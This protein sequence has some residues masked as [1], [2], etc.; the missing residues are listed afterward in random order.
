MSKARQRSNGHSDSR[1]GDYPSNGF[2]AKSI[3]PI[4]LPPREMSDDEYTYHEGR[5][6]KKIIDLDERLKD[7]SQQEADARDFY[8]EM[9]EKFFD[10]EVDYSEF[11]R[12]Y[13]VWKKI[14]NY[15]V[16]VEWSFNGAKFD[17]LRLGVSKL[18]TPT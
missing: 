18:S 3:G 9:S 2:G 1:K 12:A 8:I 11:Q 4:F 10:G 16:S 6:R 5:L 15:R 14:A 7:L 13:S 17:M